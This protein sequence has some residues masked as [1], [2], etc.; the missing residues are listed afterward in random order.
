MERQIQRAWRQLRTFTADDDVE[1]D[2]DNSAT[3]FDAGWIDKD[4]Q[5]LKLSNLG[6]K[7]AI[8]LRSDGADTE[9]AQISIWGYK[10]KEDA[11]LICIATAT[12]GP[13][14]NDAASSYN[15]A[16]SWVVNTQAW[17]EDVVDRDAANF[18]GY[19]TFPSNGL[20]YITC[21]V[22]ATQNTSDTVVVEM[23]QY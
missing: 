1:A 14:T 12:N 23:V 8:R 4:S 22:L 21:R 20:E 13:A 17:Y 15:W 7:V 5:V 10:H 9:T 3:G 2:I 11:E 6:S 16:E 19:L 18:I